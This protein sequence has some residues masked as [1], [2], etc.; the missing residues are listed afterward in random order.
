MIFLNSTLASRRYTRENPDPDPP[1]IYENPNLIPKLLRQ[2]SAIP[3]VFKC[4]SCPDIF[5]YLK[6][7]EFD[8]RL[9]IS[10]FESKSER[11]TDYTVPNPQFLVDLETERANRLIDNYIAEQPQTPIVIPSQIAHTPPTPPR[12][13]PPRVMAA[14]FTPLVLPQVLDDMPSNY[15]SKIPFFDDTTNGI[16]TQQHVDKMADFYELHEIDEENVAMR[17]FVQTFA[18]DV[19]KWFRGLVK[20]SINSLA[21]LQRQFLNRWEVKKNPLQ[22]LAEYEQIKTNS[23]ESVQDYCVRFNT[24][25][26]EI[27]HHLKPP[28]GLAM[29]KFPDGFD[30]DMAYQLREREPTTMEDMQKM[31]VSVEANLLSRRARAKTE[32]KTTVKEESSSMDQLLKKVEQM[33]ERVKLDKPEPQVR[34]PNFRGQQ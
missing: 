1:Q 2:E 20:V 33:L 18:G 4:H 34:N 22:I 23:G 25:Y 24:V 26:N 21:E 30:A 12:L 14:Q 11:A 10:L 16:T 28:V 29:M 32:K 5:D 27:P 7:I 3:P 31:V 8:E 13:N 6:E 9:E 17:L 19:R 15:Q